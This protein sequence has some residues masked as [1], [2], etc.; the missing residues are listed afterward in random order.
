MFKYEVGDLVSISSDIDEY[1]TFN[2]LYDIEVDELGL[3]VKC[4]D[5]FPPNKENSKYINPSRIWYSVRFNKNNIELE[6]E[7]WELEAL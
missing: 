3:V 4:I 7:E 1:N 2:E 6:F 5:K